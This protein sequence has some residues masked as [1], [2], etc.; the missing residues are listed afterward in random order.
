[1]AV[2]DMQ[3]P[4]WVLDKSRYFL[5]LCKSP[6]G[7]RAF[8]FCQDCMGMSGMYFSAITFSLSFRNHGAADTHPS[9]C[10]VPSRLPLMEGMNICR[11]TR[12][13]RATQAHVIPEKIMSSRMIYAEENG[14]HVLFHLRGVVYLGNNH[15]TSYR[16]S[17]SG[18]MWY[19]DGIVHWKEM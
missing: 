19:H 3:L 1:V 9:P 13:N 6:R 17:Q 14:E 5:W 11:S 4:Q 8:G 2:M 7:S 12:K 15:F 10:Q 16:I 18:N